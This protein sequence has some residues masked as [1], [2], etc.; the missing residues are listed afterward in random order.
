MP[1]YHFHLESSIGPSA[2]ADGR[3]MPDDAAAVRDAGSTA[4]EVLMDELTAGNA[5]PKVA[6]T[7][8]RSDGAKVAIV[9]TYAEVEIF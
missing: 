1:R 6:V 3:D 4:G 5:K 8:E 7:V 9:K 2:D